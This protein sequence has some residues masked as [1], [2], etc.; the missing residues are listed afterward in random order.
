VVSAAEAVAWLHDLPALW[1][2]ADDTGRRLLTEAIFEKV[3]VLGVQSVTIHPTPEADAHGWSE[4][5]G[6]LP[7]LLNAG[8]AS[9]TDGRGERTSGDTIQLS[10][11]IVGRVAACP[12]INRIAQ[13]PRPRSPIRGLAR[14]ALR[15]P[16][17]LEPPVAGSAAG[18]DDA[19]VGLTPRARQDGGVGSVTAIGGRTTTIRSMSASMSRRSTTAAR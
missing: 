9:S 2:A 19:C 14:A 18:S 3:E 10:V 5:F 6:T 16:Y 13:T 17:V 8:R 7:L 1:T 12:R 15:S 11:R 4:A